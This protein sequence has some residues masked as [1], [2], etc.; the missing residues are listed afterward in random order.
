MLSPRFRVTAALAAV[1]LTATAGWPLTPAAADRLQPGMQVWLHAH[2]CY[3]EKGLWP[4]R[5]DRALAVRSSDIAIEQDVAWFVD[6]ATGRGRSVVSHD[7]KP[8]GT[9][10]TL[11]SYFFDRVRPLMDTALKEGR[12]DTWPLMVLHLDF[13]TNEPAHHQAIW[14]LLGRHEAWLTTAER[15]ADE[16]RVTPFR[17]G[18]LLVMTEAGEHQVDTFHARVPV[19]ARLRIFGTVPPASFPEATTAEERAKAQVT[20]TPETLIPSGATNYRRWTNFGWASVEYGGQTN[21]GAWTKE[22]DQRLR[23]IVS[24][25][26]A[27]GLW[28]RFYTLNGHPKGQGKGWTESYNFGSADAARVRMAAARDAGVEFIASDQYEDLGQVLAAVHR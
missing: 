10:P 22:D 2:N 26:H 9:E 27:L 20:A 21:A 6:P 14:E 5:I 23:A 18:P 11:E 1:V 12:R 25:A 16:S 24:R 8:D 7:A 3:P 13:K 19:G 28:V 15:A 4:D 17:P